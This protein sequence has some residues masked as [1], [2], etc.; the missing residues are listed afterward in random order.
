MQLLDEQHLLLR[1]STEEVVTFRCYEPSYQSSFF[2]I[3]N[4]TTTKV[5]GV[6]E[7]VCDKLVNSFEYF[8]DFYRNTNINVQSLKSEDFRCVTRHS[9]QFE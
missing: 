5:I 4:F 1:Y 8:I 3:Y 6:Y 2:V 9:C 7:N